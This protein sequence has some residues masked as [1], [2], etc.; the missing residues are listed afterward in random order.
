MK[1]EGEGDLPRLKRMLTQPIGITQ[2]S[3]ANIIA[4][5]AITWNSACNYGMKLRH[6]LGRDGS[7]NMWMDD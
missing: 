6:S 5:M 3:I 2:R 7:D 4:T 1:M